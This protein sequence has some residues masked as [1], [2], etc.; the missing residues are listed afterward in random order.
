MRLYHCLFSTCTRFTELGLTA[1]SVRF[2]SRAEDNLKFAIEAGRVTTHCHGLPDQSLKRELS[3]IAKTGQNAKCW[4]VRESFS[5]EISAL[6]W[7]IIGKVLHA[8]ISRLVCSHFRCS[9]EV[10]NALHL[11][12]EGDSLHPSY[13]PNNWEILKSDCTIGKYNPFSL[14]SSEVT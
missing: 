4:T 10:D 3:Y 12:N 5:E 1:S 6:I 13:L 7:S 8:K 11:L 9:V 2:E 14:K